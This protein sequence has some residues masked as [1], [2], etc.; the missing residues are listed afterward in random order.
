VYFVRHGEPP[1]FT[2]FNFLINSEVIVQQILIVY[3]RLDASEY[4]EGNS[5]QND[6]GND[7]QTTQT[8]DKSSEPLIAVGDFQDFSAREYDSQLENGVR[9]IRL[10]ESLSVGSSR[11]SAC[12]SLN[13]YNADA[14][15]QH[16]VH[17]H[18]LGEH[19][20]YFSARSESG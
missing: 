7:S 10:L 5:P 18:Q 4:S 2:E 9:N 13:S 12:Q 1:G 16:P 11:N 20:L 14:A 8:G 3:I 19:I 17:L 6:R 15:G